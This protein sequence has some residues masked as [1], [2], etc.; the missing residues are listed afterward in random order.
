MARHGAHHSAQKSTIKTSLCLPSSASNVAS[1]RFNALSAMVEFPLWSGLHS[2]VRHL[3]DPLA[4]AGSS[5][6]E[7]E[8]GSTIKTQAYANIPVGYPQANPRRS[9][10]AP[11]VPRFLVRHRGSAALT[12]CVT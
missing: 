9:I 8:G 4:V 2:L 7:D 11:R 12:A 5:G 6:F 3:L 1:L 10:L